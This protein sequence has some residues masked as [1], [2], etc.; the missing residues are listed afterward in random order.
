MEVDVTSWEDSQIEVVYPTMPE[1][2]YTIGVEVPRSGCAFING[3]VEFLSAFV[4][5]S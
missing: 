3:L 4:N 5:R 1:G 2:N